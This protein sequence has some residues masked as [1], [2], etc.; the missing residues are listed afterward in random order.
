MTTNA[1]IDARDLFARRNFP[2]GALVQHPTHGYGFVRERDGTSR[3]VAFKQSLCKRLTEV[4]RMDWPAENPLNVRFVKS[5]EVVSH[6]AFTWEL[7]LI[8]LPS[9]SKTTEP[10]AQTLS[11]DQLAQ[12]AQVVSGSVEDQ[13]PS[14]LPA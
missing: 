10:Q 11:F 4:P 13:H 3:L 1:V 9:V 14:W 12:A 7:T 6:W 5:V 2:V 8:S